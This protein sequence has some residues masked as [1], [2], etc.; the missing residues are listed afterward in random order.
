MCM[1]TSVSVSYMCMLTS[2][3]VS[4][5]CTYLSAATA[6]NK[7]ISLHPAP[8]PTPTQLP[9]T[10][11]D[12]GKTATSNASKSKATSAAPMHKATAAATMHKPTAAATKS[13]K[14]TSK[15]KV[16]TNKMKSAQNV[17]LA[18]EL[19]QKAQETLWSLDDI[20]DEDTEQRNKMIQQ[21]IVEMDAYRLIGVR[22]LEYD[23]INRL[24]PM[25]FSS[26][27]QMLAA[28][29]VVKL[30][31]SMDKVHE[32]RYDDPGNGMKRTTTRVKPAD[33]VKAFMEDNDTQLHIIDFLM[34][35]LDVRIPDSHSAK[36]AA[37]SVIVLYVFGG[38]NT[39]QSGI[40]FP[41][42]DYN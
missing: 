23:E 32:T 34:D 25:I 9:T 11:S 36:E 40:Q 28:N 10:I 14:V 6:A 16:N 2:V 22:C 5:V 27:A 24:L 42:F 39:H 35:E 21:L 13:A 17:A 19:A 1:L 18:K 33:I 15:S 8:P 12:M 31:Q 29:K 41:I 4:Y 37:A 3:S 26:L 7:R 20:E 38:V 30:L